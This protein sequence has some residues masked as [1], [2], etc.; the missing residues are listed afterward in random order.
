MYENMAKESDKTESGSYADE[1]VRNYLTQGMYSRD[2][3][4]I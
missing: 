2:S 1:F 4:R 3:E